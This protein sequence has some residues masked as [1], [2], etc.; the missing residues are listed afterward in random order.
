[1]WENERRMSESADQG[2]KQAATPSFFIPLIFALHSLNDLNMYF[3]HKSGDGAI[4]QRTD[5][6]ATAQLYF[7]CS[8]GRLPLCPSLISHRI[9]QSASV[10]CERESRGDRNVTF[11][12]LFCCPLSANMAM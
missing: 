4:R 6:V 12:Q 8:G 7:I 3:M 2:T 10:E 1:M 11:H 9:R 5:A